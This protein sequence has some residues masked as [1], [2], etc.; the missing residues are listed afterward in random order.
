[1]TARED[2]ESDGV[3][4][5]DIGAV[6]TRPSYS[7]F[8]YTKTA[9]KQHLDARTF[10]QHW[11]ISLSSRFLPTPP[12]PPPPS[13]FIFNAAPPAANG[14]AAKGPAGLPDWPAGRTGRAPRSPAVRP[15]DPAPIGASP[16][17]GFP[18]PAH[19]VA[20]SFYPVRAL[21]DTEYINIACTPT[22]RVFFIIYFPAAVVSQ[23]GYARRRYIVYSA[24]YGG[25]EIWARD[26]GYNGPR[27]EVALFGFSVQLKGWVETGVLWDFFLENGLLLYGWEC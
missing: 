9:K 12:P 17:P 15:P 3:Q 23:A 11:T 26:R 16:P 8:V 14:A 18:R 24:A 5:T 22:T 19:A 21:P 1:M 2:D 27:G 6:N 7:S 25:V 10:H 20:S 13:R 4:Y